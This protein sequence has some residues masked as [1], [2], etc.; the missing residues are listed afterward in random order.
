MEVLLRHS[1]LRIQHCHCS[2]GGCCCS[3]C[4]IPALGTSTCLGMAKNVCVCDNV[5]NTGFKT[6]AC[7][8]LLWLNSNKP[9]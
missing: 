3:R 8:F 5:F 7:G 4:S 1:R 6:K 9:D 2:S